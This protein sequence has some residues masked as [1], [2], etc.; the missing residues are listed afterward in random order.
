MIF[1]K[2]TTE[3]KR[4]VIYVTEKELDRFKERAAENDQTVSAYVRSRLGLKT[5]LKRGA[6]EG[7]R[8]RAGKRSAKRKP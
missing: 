1:I 4:L 5:E 8:N 7:N 6:P 3:L 2:M